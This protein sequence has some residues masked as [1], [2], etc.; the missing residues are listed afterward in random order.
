MGELNSF[1]QLT[2]YST[3]LL[4][5]RIRNYMSKPWFL[6]MTLE[7][8]Q[9]PLAKQIAEIL[10]PASVTIVSDKPNGVNGVASVQTSLSNMSSV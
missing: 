10:K 9:T 5:R 8:D 2:V 1:F 4:K 6:K 7:A 3:Y